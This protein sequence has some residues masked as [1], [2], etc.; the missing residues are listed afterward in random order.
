[1]NAQVD[2]VVVGSGIVGATVSSRLAATGRRVV[3]IGDSPS[4][5][6]TRASGAMLGVLGEVVPNEPATALE[7]RLRA[8]ARYESWIEEAGIPAPSR[9][10]FLVA[11]SRRANDLLALDAIEEAARLH[12][13][14]SGRVDPADVEG[15]RPAPGFAPAR[16]LYLPGEG[17]MPVLDVLRRLDADRRVDV[18]AA[19]VIAV[20]HNDARTTGVRTAAEVMAC[21][22][23]VLCAGVATPEL[24]AR[25]GLDVDLMPAMVSAKGVGIVL[26]ARAG[27]QPQHVVRT[28]NRDFSCG[29]HLVPRGPAGVYLGGTNRASRHPR[30]LGGATAGEVVHLLLSAGQELHRA[31]PSWDLTAAP[32]GHRPLP[33]DGLPIAGRTAFPGLSIAT[34]T[35]RNG[36]LLAPLLADMV[37]CELDGGSPDAIFSPRREVVP[38][39]PLA[40]LD[41]GIG[42][43][44]E[45]LRTSE[46]SDRLQS[47]L[48][49]LLRIALGKRDGSSSTGE[50]LRELLAAYG[51]SEMIPEAL[52]ELMQHFD[53]GPPPN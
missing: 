41:E 11:S 37:A 48:H 50:G 38:A 46:W 53:V 34:G 42:D 15:L 39:D 33:V 21:D 30:V 19:A 25:S 7:L 43:L 52:V 40:I 8:A 47:L 6:A 14:A 24:L 17:W 49:A 27:E 36:V 4:Q 22:E 2:V 35:Y 45:L 3:R 13:L 9:G 12:G 44:T 1:M 5:G 29:L 18:R 28:P 32:W 23:V 16:V 31:L 26:E 10:T 51:R 20:E